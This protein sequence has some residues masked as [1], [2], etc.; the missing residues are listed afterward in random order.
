MVWLTLS[1][2]L[3]TG[4]LKAAI[5]LVSQLRPAHRPQDASLNICWKS[6]V[7]N[8]QIIIFLMQMGPPR[9]VQYPVCSVAPVAPAGAQWT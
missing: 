2:V 6:I 8:M 9:V 7:T 3:V 4:A 1:A 5:G